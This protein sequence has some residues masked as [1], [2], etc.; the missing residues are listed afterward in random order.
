MTT[1]ATTTVDSPPAPPAA[2]PSRKRF[3]RTGFLS[4]LLG[5]VCCLGS[6]LAVATGLSALSFF[7]LWMGRYQ[8]YFVLA[9]LTVMALAIYWTVRR[10]GPRTAKR[11]LVR[12]AAVMA[13][14]YVATF[15]TAAL[16]SAVVVR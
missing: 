3:A 7:P 9:S 16:V 12:H 5:G 15:G 2:L 4:G 13:A 10:F 14:V 11:M 1:C 6:A 8:V